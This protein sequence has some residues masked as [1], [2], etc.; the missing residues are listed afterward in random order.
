MLRWTLILVAQLIPQ[1]GKVDLSEESKDDL[2]CHQIIDLIDMVSD[3]AQDNKT[4]Q[5]VGLD[6]SLLRTLSEMYTSK[7]VQLACGND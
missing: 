7:W 4:L 1:N 5:R 6:Q 3:L 2:N